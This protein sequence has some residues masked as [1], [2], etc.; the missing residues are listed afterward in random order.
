MAGKS[1]SEKWYKLLKDL[2]RDDG[3]ERRAQGVDARGRTS[4]LEDY[5]IVPRGDRPQPD[6][7]E[8]FFVDYDNTEGDNFNAFVEELA[9]MVVRT[10]TRQDVNAK[11]TRRDVP[12]GEYWQVPGLF[13]FLRALKKD[14]DLD[15]QF[16][17]TFSEGTEAE[18][19]AFLKQ[20]LQGE[21]DD[22]YQQQ[23]AVL[24]L[25]E[26]P[27]G[28]GSHEQ[29]VVTVNKIVSSFYEKYRLCC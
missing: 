27:E 9:K 3:D 18:K 29:M 10:L 24:A 1:E 22:P 5:A 28:Q 21:E 17:T 4:L 16:R 26:E 23:E 6:T 15:R 25:F 13:K 12:D 8:Q 20:H 7:I 2:V 14:K 19:R 11:V